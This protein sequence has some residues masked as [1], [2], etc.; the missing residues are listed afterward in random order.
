[1]YVV[2]GIVV[3]SYNTS[4]SSYKDVPPILQVGKLQVGK[5]RAFKWTSPSH[6]ALEGHHESTQFSLTQV[7]GSFY[8]GD[9]QE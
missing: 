7:Q 4:R 2:S 6:V 9:P 1:M 5:L 3:L 8:S